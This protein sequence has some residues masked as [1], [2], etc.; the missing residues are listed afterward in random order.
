MLMGQ[1]AFGFIIGMPLADGFP[2]SFISLSNADITIQCGSFSKTLTAAADWE[3]V[4]TDNPDVNIPRLGYM[5][6]TVVTGQP[7]FARCSFTVTQNGVTY[8]GSAMTAARRGD[9][10]SICLDTC[11]NNGFGPISPTGNFQLMKEW[12]DAG[13]T[14][15][16]VAHPDDHFGYISLLMLSDADGTGHESTG[17]SAELNASW[18]E[19]EYDYA[20]VYFSAF[21]L[22]EN[23]VLH[24]VQAGYAKWGQE[25]LNIWRYRNLNTLPQWGDWDS[26]Q[27]EMGWDKVPALNPGFAKAERLW[28]LFMWPLVS[29]GS[30]ANRAT[31]KH[32][33]VN[34]GNLTIVAPDSITLGTGNGNDANIATA[35]YG[36]TSIFTT[37]QIY[38][39]L[40]GLNTDSAFKIPLFANSIKFMA[41]PASVPVN[42]AKFALGAQN[43]MKNACLPEYR[44]W[45]TAEAGANP[46]SIMANPKTNGVQGTCITCHGDMHV[47]KVIRH[48]SPAY[49]GNLAENFYEFC[50]G[51]G[52][53]S[54]N[55]GVAPA[56]VEGYTYDGSTIEVIESAAKG[57]LSND[58]NWWWGM[59]I[60]IDGETYPPTMRLVNQDRNGEVLWDKK[61]TQYRSM[62][63]AFQTEQDVTAKGAAITGETE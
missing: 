62:N 8:D 13:N 49:T 10:Y 47:N 14:I 11:R 7:A 61:F 20:M 41:D 34:F 46:L 21:G 28:N 25:D 39:C 44:A 19:L 36:P 32:W 50:V 18:T 5:A 24:P 3:E 12:H 43:P 37:N 29:A 2:V 63:Y 17:W 53:G 40:D 26:G 23:D 9:K 35:N 56:I 1:Q 55:F 31:A 4:G 15:L 45:F 52:N 48:Q 16:A 51:T 54:I 59:R 27:N 38:D 57:G 42:Q 22:F 6:S 60:D 30:L 33:G 58:G